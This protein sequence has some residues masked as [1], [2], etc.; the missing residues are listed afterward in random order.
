LAVP[1]KAWL[2]S[3]ATLIKGLLAPD[4]IQRIKR[5]LTISNPIF[6]QHT[7]LQITPW[8]IPKNL[9]Y[10][11]E[12]PKGNLVVPIGYFPRILSREKGLKFLDKRTEGKDIKITFKGTP[13]PYQQEA[14]DKMMLGTI[15]TIQATTGSGKTVMGIKYITTRKKPTLILVDTIE[16]ANQWMDRIKSFTNITEVGMIGNGSYEVRPITVALLQSM[17]RMD[18][19]TFKFLGDYFGVVICDEVHTVAAATYYS[20]MNRLSCKYKFGLSA[21]P[22]REDGL[23]DVIFWATGKIISKI[24]EERLKN[25]LVFPKYEKV[26]TNYH[27]PL[28]SVQDYAIMLNDLGVD[29][30]RND[31]IKTTWETKAKNK[32]TVI[33]C[34]RVLQILELQKRIPGSM[35][36]ISSLTKEQKRV[37]KRYHNYTDTDI[38]LIQDQT[39]KK[40]REDVIERL[41]DGSCKTVISTYQLFNKGIDIKTLEILMFAGPFRSEI[42]LKQSRGRIM[43]KHKG[44]QALILDFWDSKVDLLKFQ[45]YSRQ[46]AINQL[47]H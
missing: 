16:L 27:F 22:N 34:S 39:K 36:L 30:D 2:S 18:E 45:A 6:E 5:E 26:E 40:H 11:K 25:H 15:G 43:R 7:K 8:G 23:T 21:T 44:K 19:K 35:I 10:W 24:G 37:M 32:Q 9:I 33:L 4:E 41:N 47:K 13:R 12:D 29:P 20:T 3:D 46:R 17:H 42:W 14:V 38:K 31:L 28:F 1:L